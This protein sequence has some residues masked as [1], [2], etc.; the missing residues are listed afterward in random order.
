M[1]SLHHTGR[2][3]LPGILFA[4]FC[5]VAL[6]LWTGADMMHREYFMWDGPP[7]SLFLQFFD[8]L[9]S[10]LGVILYAGAVFGNVF[11]YL[12]KRWWL[13]GISTYLL[14]AITHA[15][16]FVIVDARLGHFREITDGI[17]EP[18]ALLLVFVPPPL[19]AAG[20]ALIVK[21]VGNR[22]KYW[23]NQACNGEI[24]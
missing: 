19:L 16:T 1:Q 5:M 22:S 15:I 10:M 6:G 21:R 24:V 8:H 3:A 4:A 14:W 9:P 18:L 17:G 20:I 11:A 23:S 13:F 2:L 7:P 12:R